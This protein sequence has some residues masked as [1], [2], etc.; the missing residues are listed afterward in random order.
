AN[1]RGAIGEGFGGLKSG[2]GHSG[3][4]PVLEKCDFRWWLPAAA[5]QADNVF[6]QILCNQS[7]QVP[8]IQPSMSQQ[9]QMLPPQAFQEALSVDAWINPDGMRLIAKFH[10]GAVVSIQSGRIGCKNIKTLV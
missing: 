4:S 2:I 3:S 5:V 1:Y 10:I 9:A 7:P 6:G 8:G